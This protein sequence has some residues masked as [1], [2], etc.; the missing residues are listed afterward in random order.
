[1]TRRTRVRPT[2]KTVDEYLAALGEDQRAALQHLRTTIRAIVP[3]AEECISYRIPAF[4]LDGKVLVWFG[5]ATNHCAFYP[6][7]VVEAYKAEL[8]DFETRKGTIRF[9]AVHP[10]PAS[11]V[12]TLVKARIARLTSPTRQTAARRG[13]RH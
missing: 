10:L 13:R 3:R 8:K 12:R 5:A 9:H 6:G 1:M 2:P 4:R 11:I 7:A